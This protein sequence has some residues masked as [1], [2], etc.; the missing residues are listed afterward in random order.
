VLA[1]ARRLAPA[2]AL[3]ALAVALP[4]HAVERPGERDWIT[5][6]GPHHIEGVDTAGDGRVIVAGQSFRLD[7]PYPW[8]HAYLPDGRRDPGFGREGAVDFPDDRRSMVDTVVQP[9]GRILVAEDGHTG[10]YFT[11]DSPLVRRLT[12]TAGPTPALVPA[13]R[14]SPTSPLSGGFLS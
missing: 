8:V 3:A 13:A 2:A 5:G 4:A 12:P 10:Y 6:F 1:G 11:K 9:D 7:P 14:S